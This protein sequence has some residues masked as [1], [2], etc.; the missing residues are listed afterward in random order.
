MKRSP[1]KRS[2]KPR[3]RSRVSPA[4][5]AQR[6][7]CR[8]AVS[9]V[10]GQGPCDPA[11]LWD[12]SVGGCDHADC[13]IPLTREEHRAYDEGNLDLSPYLISS[14]CL[15]EVQHALIHTKGSLLR[16]M[17]RVSGSQWA[18]TDEDKTG[19]ALWW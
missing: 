3:K 10:S 17:V 15:A 11:H 4:S 18:P 13:V 8:D 12:R 9:I 6:E 1:I 19:E 16:L 2:T 14:G 5:P 7:K